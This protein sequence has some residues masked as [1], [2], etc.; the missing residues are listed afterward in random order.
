MCP[1]IIAHRGSSGYMTDNTLRSF[2]L[3]YL[4][5]A[6]VIEMDIRQA[7]DALVVFHDPIVDID[8]ISCKIIETSSSLLLRK[9]EIPSLESV[10]KFIHG[11][12]EI[13]INFDVKPCVMDISP[14]LQYLRPIDYLNVNDNY[15]NVNDNYLN[16]NDNYLNVN[17]SYNFNKILLPCSV[18]YVPDEII[19]FTITKL[20]HLNYM[21]IDVDFV[22]PQLVKKLHR[23]KIKVFV[24][25]VNKLDQ[26]ALMMSYG[27]DGI[28]TDFPDVIKR[29]CMQV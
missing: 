16:V 15:L 4:Q 26:L 14:I 23:N 20:A 18:G 5:E 13:P 22:T 27:V 12:G 11:L 6:D 24:Y 3:A 8:G 29:K 7:K 28:I 2:K 17:D 10:V 19:P 21:S 1:L 9:C 25:T